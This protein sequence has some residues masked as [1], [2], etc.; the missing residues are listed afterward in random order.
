MVLICFNQ[1]AGMNMHKTGKGG[2]DEG[3]SDRRDWLYWFPY[4]C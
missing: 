2:K 1:C 3:F 4:M